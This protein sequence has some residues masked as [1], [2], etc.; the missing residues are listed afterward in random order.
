[1]RKKKGEEGCTPMEGWGAVAV[2]RK[3]GQPWKKL[4]VRTRNSEEKKK[5]LV[6]ARKNRGVGVKNCQV[7][8]GEHLYL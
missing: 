4:C 2:G 7:Q 5:L 1:L 6:A 3:R 8:G